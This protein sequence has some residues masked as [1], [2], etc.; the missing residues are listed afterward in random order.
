LNVCAMMRIRI[1]TF[2]LAF[3]VAAPVVMHAQDPRFSQFFASPLT[4][5]PALTGRFDGNLRVAGNYRNQWPTINRAFTTGTVSVDFP[6]MVGKLPEIDRWGV[7]V[8]A[9]SDQQ[10][11]GVLKNTFYSLSTAYHKGIDEDGFHSVTIGFQGT[12]AQK[13]L[14][15]GSLK[16][17]DQLRS[18]GFTGITNEIFDPQNLNINYF[19]M[20]VGLLF[21]GVMQGN[22]NYYMGGSLYH[23]NKPTE[24]FTGADFYLNQRFTAHGGVYLPLGQTTTLHTSMLYQSQA[25]AHETVL[26]GALGFNL[27]NDMEYSPT[28]FYAGAWMRF[29]DALIP[30]IGLEWGKFRLGAS[31]DINT[32]S[33]K[34]A[35]S[36]RGGFEV[37][38]IYI[39]KRD[40]EVGINCPKF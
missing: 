37:S 8:Q 14:N 22:I 23:I 19:D 38:L 3:L 6:V 29:G 31:Y 16:F 33:L 5:N 17:E 4:L 28:N 12:Y 32:S 11:D 20:N 15:T 13:R 24:S 26:G 9:F 2:M 34:T 35:S 30:Y 10:A 7:G 18:D 25:G 39:N 36:S 40:G 27:N 1:F 21:S